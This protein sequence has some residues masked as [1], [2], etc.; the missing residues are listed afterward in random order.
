[1]SAPVT[2]DPG[3]L[4]SI[5]AIRSELA[6]SWR[7]VAGMDVWQSLAKVF[8]AE[9]FAAYPEGPELEHPSTPQKSKKLKLEQGSAEKTSHPRAL[10]GT[11]RKAPESLSGKADKASGKPAATPKAKLKP[12]GKRKEV[13]PLTTEQKQ[14]L[15]LNCKGSAIDVGSRSMERTN[16][17]DATARSRR[18]AHT[19]AWTVCARCL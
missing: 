18:C 2:R 3:A 15:M 5:E 6:K 11:M 17:S 19:R 16:S 7:D 10:C 9:A 13:A 4:A 8:L 14:F 1:M 12:T